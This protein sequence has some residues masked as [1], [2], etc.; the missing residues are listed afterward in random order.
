MS[1]SKFTHEQKVLAAKGALGVLSNT[2]P[3]GDYDLVHIP[4]PLMDD[5]VASL[6]AAMNSYESLAAEK[7]STTTRTRWWKLRFRFVDPDPKP[8]RAGCRMRW[9]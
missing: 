9:I 7:T 2:P 1:R 3:R 5:L 6:R 8:A 4:K